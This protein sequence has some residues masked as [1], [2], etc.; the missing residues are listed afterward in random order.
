MSQ[1]RA[2]YNK[3]NYKREILPD[4]DCNVCSPPESRVGEELKI[5]IMNVDEER[6]KLNRPFGSIGWGYIRPG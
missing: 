4:E 5:Q 1:T 3:D 2:S 6:K